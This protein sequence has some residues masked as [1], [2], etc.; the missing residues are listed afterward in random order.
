MCIYEP[1][2]GRYDQSVSA[3]WGQDY[4]PYV[5]VAGGPAQPRAR[6][7]GSTVLSTGDPS[8]E[9]ITSCCSWLCLNNSRANSWPQQASFLPQNS[10]KSRV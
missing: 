8:D 2:D 10:N 5:A 4:P 9:S 1:P 6:A 3:D 7:Q